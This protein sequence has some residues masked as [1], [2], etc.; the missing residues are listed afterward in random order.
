MAKTID[1]YFSGERFQELAEIYL[2][3][4]ERGNKYVALQRIS[5][6]NFHN[7]RI[8]FVK[9]DYLPALAA[10]VHSF[11]NPFVLITHNSDHALR[12]T[13]R[14]VQRILQCEKL[15][16]WWGQ[17]LLF[18]THPK[19]RILPIGLANS[20][21]EHGNVQPFLDFQ[22]KINLHSSLLPK[23][24]SVYFHFSIATSP[25]IRQH[26]FDVLQSKFPFLPHMNAVQ[27]VQ[28]MAAYQFCICPE[29]NGPDTHRLWEAMFVRCVPIVVR[30]PFVDTLMH[31]TENTLPLLVLDQWEQLL[32]M[33]LPSYSHFRFDSV[34]LT[35]DGWR[36]AI[37]ASA[38]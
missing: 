21:W 9:P 35:M 25:T 18:R 15:I 7:P 22:T 24:H 23:P 1:F 10:K 27:N 32:T 29:G 38:K 13:D 2:G 31:F 16:C 3:A 11:G 26:C 12:E 5:P 14:N 4:A 34:W 36:K 28:R 33:E 30:T 8:V 37:I 6:R 19:V 17:N 20:C